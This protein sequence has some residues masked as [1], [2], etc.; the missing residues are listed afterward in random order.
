MLEIKFR[1]LPMIG[2][3][4]ASELYPNPLSPF[5]GASFVRKK[6]LSHLSET[7]PPHTIVSSIDIWD[8]RQEMLEYMLK[9]TRLPRVYNSGFYIHFESLIMSSH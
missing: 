9:A 6:W 3:Y 2:E 5:I 8:K 4:P 1:D 7:P